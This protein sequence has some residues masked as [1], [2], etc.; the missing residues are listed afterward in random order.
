MDYNDRTISFHLGQVRARF[1]D[2][3]WNKDTIFNFD[4]THFVF[5]FDNGRALGFKG[6]TFVSYAEVSNGT[7][8]LTVGLLIRGG[9]NARIES[10]FVIFTTRNGSYLSAAFLTT[11]KMYHIEAEGKFGWIEGCSARCFKRQN[12]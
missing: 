6:Q 3:A 9:A 1:S 10:A 8:G 2:G 7:E 5:D 12:L 4:E 11:S